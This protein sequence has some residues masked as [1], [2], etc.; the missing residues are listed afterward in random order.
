MKIVSFHNESWEH[1]YLKEHLPG[2]DIVFFDGTLQDNADAR[3]DQA[4]VL[5]V[6]IK[7]HVGKDELDRFPNVKLITTRSTGFDHI[8]LAEA[9]ARGITVCNVPTYGENT[10]AEHVFALL[11]ALS[12]RVYE[13]YDRILKEGTF[14]PEGLRGFDLK[15]K[16][17]GVIG[18]G[19][20]GMHAIRI[21]K[22][23]E[24]NVVAFDIHRNNELA[25]SLGYRYLEF[26]EVLG[27]SDVISLHAPDNEHTHHMINSGNMDKIKRGAYL[28]NTAR[29]GLIETKALVTAL[30]QGLLAGAGLDV[31][32]EENY[33]EDDLALLTQEQPNPESLVAVLANQYLIDHPRV[34]VTP[35]NAFN[36]QEALE[37]ILATTADNIKAFSTGTA[38]NVVAPR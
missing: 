26:D 33:T 19:H 1:D 20:I 38:Q 24:M 6:F 35:H 3:D 25:E 23:F 36:T 5:S 14:S 16:T 4:D 12:R 18:T 13:S 2:E 30:E 28:I 9:A 27:T 37:R 11:L 7:S 29:G 15:G 10:V 31:L 32:E 17:M 8:D 34:I 22:G 21:A